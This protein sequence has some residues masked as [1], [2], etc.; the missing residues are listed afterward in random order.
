MTWMQRAW[1]KFR[2]L[3][4]RQRL[5][6]E[7]NDEVQFH[8]DEQIAENIAAG[9]TPKEARHAAMR[10]FG[11][12]TFLKE[13]TWEA[14][15]WTRLEQLAQDL[16]FA[17]RQ[18][19]KTPGFTAT[20][21]LT[22]AL[23]IGAN[24]S[25]FTLVNAVLMKNLPVADPAAL[26]RVGDNNSCC[27]N[28]GGVE[29]YALFSTGVYQRLQKNVPEFE[30]LA[31]M[32]AGFG[33]RSIIARRDRTSETARSVMGEF[34]SGNYFRTFGLQ[35]EAGRLF[36]D[37]DD[38]RGAPTVA[39]MS[40]ETWKRDYASDP[41]IVGGTFWVNTKPVT[42]AGIAPRGFYGDRLSSTPPDFY[43]PIQSM[44][45]LANVPYVDDP[46][47]NWLYI[48]G[49]L[50]PG[51][52]MPLLQQKVSALVK[53]WVGETKAFAGDNNKKLFD[54]VHVVLTPGG[55]GIQELRDQYESNLR[56]LMCCSGLVLLIACANIANLLLVRGMG[57]KVEMSVRTA[58]GAKRGRIVQQLMT[59]SIVLAGFSGIA[60]L[61]VA[62][63]GTRMLLAL[64][65][66]YA[67]SLPIQASPSPAVLLFA[68]GLSLLTGVLFG[69]APAWI[70]AKAEPMD[71]LRNGNRSMT[72][73]ASL[74]QRGLVVLQAAL[75]LVL[76]VGAGLF[77]Q[78]LNKLEST[79]L[80]LVSKNRYIVH[81][82][83]Q[84]AGYSQLQLEALYRTIEQRFHE[85]P[86]V[87]NVGMSSYTPMEDD[88][89]STAVQVQGQPYANQDSSVV[90]VNGEYF[91]SVGTPVVMG[92]GIGPQDISTAPTV[93]VVNRTFVK[94]VFPAGTNPIGRRF[95][96]P[97][98]DSS[99]DFEIVG[100]V[101][102]TV[103]TTARWKDHRMFFLPMMQRPASS[104]SPLEE[105]TSVYAGAIVVETAQPVNNME[106]LAREA[107]AAINPNLTVMKFQPFEQQIAD[108]FIEDRMVARLT[109]LF[110]V[111]ALLLATIGLYGVTAYTVARRT[112]EIGLRMALGAARSQVV[113]M[114]MRS[115]LGQMLIGL[116]IGLPVAFLCVR[117]VKTQLYE[118][119]GVDI[120]VM[121]LAVL[122]LAIASSFA[123]L[124]PA[125]RA[126]SMDPA[127][128][129]RTE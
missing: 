90:R 117:F 113:G 116:A 95:G 118:V 71:A 43:L 85:M 109:T 63:V 18:L 24:A 53:Q 96:A 58:L 92:R 38:R 101:E 6:D 122:T 35:P 93:A 50:K 40:Y 60:G 28:S 7:L 77:S 127:Q 31:A 115:A 112:S 83:P 13:D 17:L 8:L 46:D 23:G 75:S 39:V 27:V 76:L 42:V 73:G 2:S 5:V 124:I 94:D 89:W 57:R 4:R 126:A 47:V 87:L 97:G 44:P 11:N 70:A 30:E 79:D 107:L 3:F 20:A 64:A 81:I 9:M 54:H 103:Y 119:Q 91:A 45:A 99:G 26:V 61:A 19:K 29:D 56:L 104:K 78:S 25:I 33:F 123:G 105:D 125:R 51:V 59:E 12:E 48:I 128:T 106:Q 86:G 72:T 102:D 74:L 114:V 32:Q 55:A 108:R 88:N 15:G 121:L 41:S 110:G 10:A 66:P 21:V 98:P 36:S 82:N 68:C 1:Q 80:K 22:L 65:F 69:V 120:G 67:H 52:P 111:V 129:L 84:T 49:R 37:D 100:V 34:V 62:F 16:R 14:W